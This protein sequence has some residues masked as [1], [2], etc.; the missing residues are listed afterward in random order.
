[1]GQKYLKTL[2]YYLLFLFLMTRKCLI[3]IILKLTH[4]LSQKFVLPL[5][6]PIYHFVHLE[7]FAD[8]KSGES[9]GRTLK[10]GCHGYLPGPGAKNIGV[11]HTLICSIPWGISEFPTFW[12]FADVTYAFNEAFP[13]YPRFQFY[14]PKVTMISDLS[15]EFNMESK[16]KGEA[17]FVESQL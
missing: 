11:A 2:P 10:R 9:W 7:C 5:V 12:T 17:W 16:G 1:M 13:F 8:I 14:L 3:G 4:F 15:P 6:Q